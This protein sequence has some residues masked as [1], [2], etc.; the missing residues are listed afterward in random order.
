MKVTILSENSLLILFEQDINPSVFN[1][2]CQCVE[3]VK[4]KLSVY[5]I[6]MVPSYT[7]IHIVF[8]L[9]KISGDELAKKL[10]NLA[11]QLNNA[12]QTKLQTK[13]IEIPVYYGEEVG[14]DCALLAEFAETSVDGVIEMHSS[15]LYDVYAIGFAP[16]FAYLGSV[17]ERI[18][19]ARKET[20]RKKVAKGSVGIADAQT[21]VYPADSPGGWQ[22]IGCTPLKLIDYEDEALTIFKVGDKVKFVPITKASY[23]EM[24]GELAVGGQY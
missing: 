21:A 8:N 13:I 2:V 19:M 6:D 15:K 18:A 10:N 16:G 11:D 1:Q 17:D 14:L 9:F 23:L 5:I 20:P 24:G 3:L 12:E 4:A 22:I 7:S